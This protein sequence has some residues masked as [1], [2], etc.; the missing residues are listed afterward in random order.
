MNSSD[1][2]NGKIN[3]FEADDFFFYVNDY[4]SNIEFLFVFCSFSNGRYFAA[5]T[6]HKREPKTKT[7]LWNWLFQMQ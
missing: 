4:L 7:S 5:S 6:T 1:Q 2:I 3:Y